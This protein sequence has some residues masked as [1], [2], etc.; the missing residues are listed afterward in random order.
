MPYI[1]AAATAM[2]GYKN[3]KLQHLLHLPKYT[4]RELQH[5][6]TRISSREKTR[7]KP[8]PSI[9]ALPLLRSTLEE[10]VQSAD[11]FLAYEHTINGYLENTSTRQRTMVV[12]IV[13]Q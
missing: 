13:Q 11:S 6:D 9:T 8:A 3:I 2:L 1:P 10:A 4:P 7:A 5:W 12:A